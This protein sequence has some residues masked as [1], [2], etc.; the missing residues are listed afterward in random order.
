MEFDSPRLLE[1]LR[2]P[3]EDLAFEIKD[4]LDLSDNAHKA[5]LAQAMI[6]L[7]NYGG[8]TVLIGY[9]E[10]SDGTFIQNEARPADLTAY[11]AD[12][13]NEIS[14]AYLSPAVHCEV[15]HI[16]HPVSGLPFPAVRVPGGHL[17]PIIAKRGGP[18]G[19]SS[20]QSGR[21]Y[22]RRAGPASEEP[23]SP[24]EWRALLDRCVR[25]G[26][27]DL[28]DRI[29][30]IVAGEPLQAVAAAATQPFDQWIAD[31]RARWEILVNPLSTTHPARFPRGYY[32]FA[33]QIQADFSHPS[34]NVLRTAIREAEVR[35]SGWPHWPVIERDP[36]RPTPIDD[37]IECFMARDHDSQS[38]A[39]D[40][41]DFWRVSTSGQA[42]SVRGYA[43]DSHA[44][45]VEPGTG[46][47]ITTPTWR[48]ADAIT[49]A[50]NLARNLQVSDGTVDFDLFYQG[51]QGRRLVSVGNSGRILSGT[52]RTHQDQYHRRFS[53]S[54]STALV[55]LPEIVDAAL[56]PLYQ[57]FDFFDLP[58]SLTT[59]EIAQWRRQ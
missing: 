26:R 28:I 7:A 34:L 2:N 29:R 40:R 4:W 16:N 21:T 23:Q 19:Q 10:R 27:E 6:A 36:I 53:F 44:D 1:L 54:I 12:A 37:T 20:L 25:A 46:F 42:F 35:T 43:E 51:L 8:G 31:S 30:L 58:A 48:L 22:I 45:L 38:L 50:V 39:P 59:Q 33:Y 15:R 55:Q 49:H 56:R 18:Q 57:S 52:R 47:D 3:A 32:Q 14:R 9:T 11:T 41:L 17:T 13:I 24:E 5:K